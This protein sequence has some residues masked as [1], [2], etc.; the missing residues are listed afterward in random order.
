VLV[1]G[2]LR[3]IT[4]FRRWLKTGLKPEADRAAPGAAGVTGRA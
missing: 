1:A 2:T 3:E 4:A